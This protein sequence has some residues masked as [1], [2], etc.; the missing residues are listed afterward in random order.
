MAASGIVTKETYLRKMTLDGYVVHLDL[1]A[2]KEMSRLLSIAD[3]NLNQIAKRANENRSIF[4]SDIKSI[5]ADYE[6]LWEQVKEIL[7]LL[8]KMPK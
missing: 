1:S 7:K 5:Q 2:I 3:N 4:A 6:R 8:T